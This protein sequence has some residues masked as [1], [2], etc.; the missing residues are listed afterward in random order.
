[1]G[2]VL[3]I[4]YRERISLLLPILF[5]F[6]GMGQLYVPAEKNGTRVFFHFNCLSLCTVFGYFTAFI[7]LLKFI[8]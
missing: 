8:P 4:C 5:F 2:N 7:T 1:M 6:F 3:F